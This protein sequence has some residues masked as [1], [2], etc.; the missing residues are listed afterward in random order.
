QGGLGLAQFALCVLLAFRLSRSLAVALMLGAMAMVVA[1]Y[2]YHLRPEIFALLFL[3]A[4]LLVL[5]AYQARRD[6]RVLLWS[7]PIALLWANSHGSFLLGPIVCGLFALGEGIEAL[8]GKAGAP[9]RARLR[10][11]AQQA[12]PFALAS[13]GTAALSLANPLG[14]ELLR[15]AL[16]LS[17]S[18]VTKR[19]V[20]EWT[21]TLSRDFM[22]RAPFAIFMGSIATAAAVAVAFRRRLTA[23]DVLLLLAFGFLALQRTRFVA[24]FG[25]VMLAVCARL[26]GSGTSRSARERPL[27]VVAIGSAIASI[28]LT[29]QFGNVWGAFPYRSPSY[30]FS[31]PMLERLA[32]PEMNGN[33]F[34][35]FELGG[36]LIYRGYPR[37]RPSIDSRIDSYG[38]R[39]FVIHENLLEE[40]P[41]MNEFIADFD[42]RYMLLLWRDFEWVKRND[43]LKQ[44]WRVAFAD[45]KMV[46]LE[47]LS[48]TPT[49]PPGPVKK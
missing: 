46:L 5:T 1:N 2:R 28:A 40:P 43:G 29:L 49:G 11:A 48:A 7:A 31:A 23:T 33:V 12:G 4:L 26:I 39:Y 18:E 9:I 17:A 47:R 15:F 27:L 3:V 21:P 16:T 45:H 20:S 25:F 36:E 14:P 19:F 8:R 30:N 24:L 6:W 38:D 10:A 13:I 35:S 42:V 44:G 22:T 37:L 34:N 41:L 32:R